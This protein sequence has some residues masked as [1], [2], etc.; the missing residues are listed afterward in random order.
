M[1]L[2]TATHRHEQHFWVTVRRMLKLRHNLPPVAGCT[3]APLPGPTWGWST[4]LT[5]ALLLLGVDTDTGGRNPL[6]TALR[7]KGATNLTAKLSAS[8]SVR[9]DS[10]QGAPVLWENAFNRF[11]F[12]FKKKNIL[13]S[14]YLSSSILGGKSHPS[15][16]PFTTAVGNRSFFPQPGTMQGYWL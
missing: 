7:A 14:C 15:Q 8:Q 3:W 11:F 10:L 13:H 2:I 12:F 6:L 16:R 9:T 5:R 1:N 4:V